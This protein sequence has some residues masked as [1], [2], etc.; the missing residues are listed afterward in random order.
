MDSKKNYLNP[1]LIILR[2]FAIL[3]KSKEIKIE[4][5]KEMK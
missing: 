1:T 5:W 2:N 3:T 4:I